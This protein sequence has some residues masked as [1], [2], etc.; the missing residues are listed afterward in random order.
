MENI[1]NDPNWDSLTRC[2]FEAEKY[3]EF[4]SKHKHDFDLCNLILTYPNNEILIDSVQTVFFIN[5]NFKLLI[6]INNIKNR[7]LN[8]DKKYRNIKKLFEDY[9]QKK[10]K[11]PYLI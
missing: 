5:L 9:Q 6:I 3:M 10:T 1:N 11:R 2:K 8:L 7:K 4:Y